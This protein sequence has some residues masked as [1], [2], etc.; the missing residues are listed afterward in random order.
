MARGRM[1]PQNLQ[2]RLM[3]CTQFE[4]LERIHQAWCDRGINSDKS[5]IE[6]DAEDAGDPQGEPALLMTRI[7]ETTVDMFKSVLSL[8]P[9]GG[10]SP[11]QQ[12]NDHNT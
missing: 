6:D 7:C 1:H 9:G 10:G 12:P 5:T 3:P 11:L 4:A 2:E 8:Q